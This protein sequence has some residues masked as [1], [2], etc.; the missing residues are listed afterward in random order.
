MT[1]LRQSLRE[2]SGSAPLSSVR[3]QRKFRPELQGLRALAAGLVV[4]YHVWLGRVSGGVDVFFFVSGFLITGQ[5]FR[6]SVRGRIEF[7]PF[8]GRMFK[9]LFPAALTVI[10]VSAGVALLWLPEHR[11]IQTAKEV[12]ASALYY[13]NWQLAADSTDYLAQ[14]SGASIMQHFWSLSIQGQF[15]LVWPLLIALLMLLARPFGWNLRITLLT[16]LSSLFAGSLAYSVW[17]TEVN[18][19]FA[20]FN[21]LTRVWEFALGGLLAL[22]IDRV[23]L[24]RWLAVVA[25]WLGVVG[26]A[27]CGLVLQVG[28]MFPGYVALWPMVSALLVLLAGATGSRVGADRFLSS[29]PL[30][31]LGNISYSLYLWHWPVLL[32]YLL[33]RGRSEVGLVGGAGVIGLSL[34]LSVVTYHFVENPVRD[35]KI[36]VTTRWG[37]YRFAVLVLVPVI[38][39]AVVWQNVS[40]QRASFEFR[41]DDPRHPGAQVLTTGKPTY[42]PRHSVVP[43]FGALPGQWASYQPGECRENPV[44]DEAIV[45][46]CR[47]SPPDGV[48]PERRIVV[49]GDSHVWQLSSALIP[50]A[51]EESWELTVLHR[52]GC[53]LT[54]TETAPIT[55]ECVEWNRQTLAK[56]IELRPDAVVTMAT[57]NVRVGLTERTP[58][59]YV[60]QWQK[61]DEAGIPVVGVRDNPRFDF[62]P[63]ACVQ[64]QGLDAEQCARPRREL[65][66]EVA[67]Y[68][69][70]PGVPA[71]T[72]FVDLSDYFCTETTCPPV[73][74]NVLVYMDD[75]HVTSTYMQT[76]SPIMKR[77]LAFALG[78]D[79]LPQPAPR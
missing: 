32:F 53:P 79:E 31:Y 65:Y 77:E 37:A 40:I 50:I 47:V 34:V 62:D 10:V 70:M 44:E 69:A 67:P 71:N 16:V 8:W 28:T 20:Y 75:N 18:Q 51:R 76:L 3:Q 38:A 39:G 26:L 9:R 19:P 24:P 12:L 7:R 74:G 4:V 42:D 2:E 15:Y 68:A 30:I 49:A 56:I 5:L 46:E 11:W 78:W 64:T 52:A 23:V 66:D 54:A 14:H 35:S 45:R 43:P 33:V 58:E 41:A 73:I 22:T 63:S 60:R 36:G 48:V 61:L 17:L 13:E 72:S 25:G 29:R 1:T 55:A 57:R 59:G 21:S 27:S 6:A